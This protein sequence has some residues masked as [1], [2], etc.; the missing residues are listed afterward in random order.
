MH[1]HFFIASAALVA[2][3]SNTGNAL[4]L[5]VAQQKLIRTGSDLSALSQVR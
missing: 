3:L 5:M 2:V 1:K 4:D